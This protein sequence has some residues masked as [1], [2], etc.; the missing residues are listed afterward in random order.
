VRYSAAL[1]GNEFLLYEFKVVIALISKGYSANQIR[2]L[3]IKCNLFKYL[4]SNSIKKRV[5]AV[6]ERC[7]SL[8][9]DF[10]NYLAQT[11]NDD[12]YRIASLSSI[13]RTNNLFADFMIDV[14]VEKYHTHKKLEL[15]EI[16]DFFIH[17]IEQD[18]T[19]AKWRPQTINKLK[20]VFIRILANAGLIYSATDLTFKYY[21]PLIKSINEI[22][23]HL[24]P[25]S[26][27]IISYS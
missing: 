3:V 5:N 11:N 15:L 13:I 8:E 14:F 6:L 25:I 26:I 20:S 18:G 21:P 10:I 19:I 12:L 2:E 7:N 27:N 16:Q 1:T 22:K 9:I 23:C 17:K 4:S 24:D